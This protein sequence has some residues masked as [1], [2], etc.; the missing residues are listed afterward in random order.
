MKKRWPVF[1][2]A[3][4]I[5]QL[6]VLQIP[7]YAHN[8]D[9][10]LEMH[11]EETVSV[12]NETTQ[13]EET[14]SLDT[15][16]EIRENDT[17]AVSEA[18]RLKLR[19]LE[20]SDIHTAI[21]NYDYFQDTSTDQFGLVRTAS[22]IRQAQEEVTNSML[23]DNGD[24]LQGN[25]MGDYIARVDQLK[26]EG[27]IH[28]AYKAM[29][30]LDYDAGNIG[31][32]EFNF[33]LE[34]L[35]R[36]LEGA[37]FPYVNANVYVDDHDNDPNN[38]VNYFTPYVILDRTFVDEAG[39]E[40]EMKVGVI[41]F[42]PPQIMQWD[43]SNLEGK[44][45]A[46]DIVETAET[47]VP[48]M[49]DEG[50]DLII[51]IPHSGMGG[52]ENGG[53]EE[54][55]A[56]LLSQVEGIN[57]ILFGHAHVVFPG[58]SF[59]DQEGI[60]NEKG[61]I[62]GVPAVEPGYWGNHLGMIDMTLE[63]RD[64]EW[65]LVDSQSKVLPI[66][67]NVDGEMIPLVDS[68]QEI[69]DAVA[70]DHEATLEY[71]RG[72]VGTTAAPINSY[73]AL[74]QDDPSIQLVTNAQKWYVEKHIQGTELDGIPVLSAG[75]PF[76]AGGSN[77]SNYTNIPEGTIAIKNVA[78]LY[79]FPN[80]LKAVKLNGD[81]VREWLERSAG[82]FNQI[83]VTST[84]EQSIINTNFPTYLYDVIDGVSYQI[85]LTQPSRYNLD[86]ELVNPDAHRIVNLT[87]EGEPVTAEMEFLVATNNYRAGGGGRFPNLDGSNIVVDSPD[88]TRQIIID[89]I[90]TQGEFNPSA[91]GNWSFKP[92]EGDVNVTFISSPDAKEFA[93][94]IESVK[95]IRDE[96]TGFAT[97]QIDMS[98]PPVPVSEA[99]STESN[100]S[101]NDEEPAEDSA[102]DIVYIVQ[103]GDWLFKIALKYGLTWQ[104]LATYNRLENPDLILIGQTLLIPVK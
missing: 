102:G 13:E 66:V 17:S 27:D 92:I 65:I 59:D 45:I 75:A 90:Q 74:V 26:E 70:E 63:Q 67:E 1:M 30:L 54:N 56:W 79:V 21:M 99:S 55:A 93:K 20:T 38:D 81:Q 52:T 78:D 98:Q 51:A 10:S 69:V 28:P 101:T 35:E 18:R 6:S 42:V 62:N 60:D 84:E 76:K 23:F 83:D 89:Y 15:D 9:A 86:G 5:L 87:Y 97:Y 85:D 44:V 71:I 77:P 57:A 2:V 104:E 33:G 61:T 8:A 73:F 24:L 95:W 91:D 103:K 68:D 22:L 41:G 47:F 50:A 4:W 43:R 16:G 29:N 58:P 34:F 88:E 46:K 12:M 96:S 7:V 39:E 37:A 94:D 36:S 64:G 14:L 40:V 100:P 25:P 31:N 80:T 19:L 48:Q 49:K 3:A 82:Q 72:P 32:H 11:Q 53:N